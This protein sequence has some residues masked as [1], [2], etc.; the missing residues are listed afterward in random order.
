MNGTLEYSYGIKVNKSR[1]TKVYQTGTTTYPKGSRLNKNAASV[2]TGS[3]NLTLTKD[4]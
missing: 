4:K 1:A 2:K 3:K